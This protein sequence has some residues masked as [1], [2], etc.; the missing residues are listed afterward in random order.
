MPVLT[1]TSASQRL[2][3]RLDKNAKL[4]KKREVLSFQTIYL[5]N[6]PTAHFIDGHNRVNVYTTVQQVSD[7]I[8]SME[9]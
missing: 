6:E 1:L 3:V 5:F 7:V 8:W 4:V 2:T 9:F